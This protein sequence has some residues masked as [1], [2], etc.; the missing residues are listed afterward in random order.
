MARVHVALGSNLGDRAAHL[1]AGLAALQRLPHTTVTAQSRVVQ[2]PALLP[3]DDPTPQPDY[4]NAVAALET[5]LPPR[6]LLGELK[7]IERAQGRQVTTR[8]APRPLDLDI[9]LW[10][11]LVLDEGDLRVP[12]PEMHR[13]AFVLEPLAE[14]AP[15]A[16]HPVLGLTVADLLAALP[17][18]S[19]PAPSSAPRR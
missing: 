16:V 18:A 10:E 12:H 19:A 7:A 13:R 17:T 6:V 2:T 9:V 15:Q 8:W 14:L 11:S 5:D 3:A 1:Q 4:F